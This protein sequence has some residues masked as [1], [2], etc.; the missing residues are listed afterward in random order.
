MLLAPSPSAV[1]TTA[2]PPANPAAPPRTRSWSTPARPGPRRS[3]TRSPLC[4]SDEVRWFAGLSQIGRSRHGFCS[5]D[6]A[7]T[8]GADSRGGNGILCEAKKSAAGGTAHC[9]LLFLLGAPPRG[10]KRVEQPRQAVR[11]QVDAKQESKCPKADGR[12][13]E[14]D[15]CAGE[16]PEDSGNQHH[17]SVP[18]PIGKTQDA[19][20]DT[21]CE[22]ERAK[23]IGQDQSAGSRLGE[24]NKP[25][26]HIQR[27]EHDLP[28]ES[29]PS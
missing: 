20:N 1:T 29:A 25:E 17:P 18:F 13:S 4:R 8:D 24:Q 2:M 19:S 6:D 3:G 26:C 14:Q 12:E 9:V 23:Q 11:D 28:Q 15:E 5:R 16:R 10:L 7:H 21:R 27:T 22:Q